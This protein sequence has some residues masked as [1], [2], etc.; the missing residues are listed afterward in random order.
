LERTTAGGE[1]ALDILDARAAP[2]LEERL[3]E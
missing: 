3:D 1:R 2:R